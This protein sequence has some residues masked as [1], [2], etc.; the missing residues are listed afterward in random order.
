MKE[1]IY[2]MTLEEIQDFCTFAM[3]TACDANDIRGVEHFASL[4]N[5]VDT[6]ACCFAKYYA[7]T[8]VYCIEHE[9]Q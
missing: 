5:I 9:K 6:V 8:K 4:A 3:K 7:E 2:S 1:R